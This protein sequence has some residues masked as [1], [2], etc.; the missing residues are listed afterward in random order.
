MTLSEVIAALQKVSQL[1]VQGADDA[2]IVLHAVEGDVKT[3]I[4]SIGVE[5]AGT[6]S[7]SGTTVTITH[8]DP[9]APAPT[10]PAPV[11]ESPP[12]EASA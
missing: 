3:A 11:D 7:P 8:G 4:H 5:I 12:A 9:P 1:V 10:E 2:E 6:G